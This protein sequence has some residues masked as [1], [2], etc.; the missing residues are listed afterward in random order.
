[1]EVECREDHADGH[2]YN[3]CKAIGVPFIQSLA[4][5]DVLKSS[6]SNVHKHNETKG[7]Q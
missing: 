7:N 3:L 1:V 6:I 4:V 5:A 2:S